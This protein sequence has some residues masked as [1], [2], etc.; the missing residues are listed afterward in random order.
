MRSIPV[1]RTAV[2]GLLIIILCAASASAID[3]NFG[4]KAG[5]MTD[6]TLDF[7]AKNTQNTNFE[8]DT[9]QSYSLGAFVQMP[10]YNRFKTILS[11][12]YHRLGDVGKS[13]VILAAQAGARYD[14]E[15]AHGRFAIRPGIAFGYGYMGD[16]RDSEE[17]NLILMNISNEF[18]VYAE[19]GLGFILEIG[20]LWNLSGSNDDY[21]IEGGPTMLVRGGLMF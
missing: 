9:Q 17:G 8:L 19:S 10:L 4:I 16:T 20:G 18:I 2:F 13:E 12:D 11:L 14:Y 7:K 5:V 15:T 21:D 6:A 1:I 3:T